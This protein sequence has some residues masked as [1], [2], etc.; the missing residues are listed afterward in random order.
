[1]SELINQKIDSMSDLTNKQKKE[2]SSLS[3]RIYQMEATYEMSR[4]K[5]EEN[6]RAEIDRASSKFD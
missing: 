1:M 2:L 6:V 4:S 5:L 3:E